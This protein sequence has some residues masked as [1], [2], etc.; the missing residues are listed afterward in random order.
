MLNTNYKQLSFKAYQLNY[1]DSYDR[2]E[3]EK[4]LKNKIGGITYEM[5]IRDLVDHFNN[6]RK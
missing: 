6:L 2:K 1:I 5:T 4:F 3:F